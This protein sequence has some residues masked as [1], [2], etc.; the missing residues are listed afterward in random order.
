MK[1][2]EYWQFSNILV[3]ADI[4]QILISQITITPQVFRDSSSPPA[5]KP[6]VQPPSPPPPAQTP[7]LYDSYTSI[8]TKHP[9]IAIR[10]TNCQPPPA[11]ERDCSSLVI[12]VR[13][14]PPLGGSSTSPIAAIA[15]STP[16]PTSSECP[17]V[18]GS[19]SWA[20]TAQAYHCSYS[21]SPLRRPSSKWF[22][23]RWRGQ[24]LCKLIHLLGE[25]CLPQLQLLP[26]HSKELRVANHLIRNDDLV[27]L[28][29]LPLEEVLLH[30]LP[31]QALHV[32]PQE[33]RKLLLPGQRVRVVGAGLFGDRMLSGLG[34]MAAI[35]FFWLL[36]HNFIIYCKDTQVYKCYGWNLQKR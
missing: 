1:P 13:T 31:P 23:P 9:P 15:S 28:L 17:S 6:P 2:N 16:P 27:M 22:A 8:P 34:E 25:N 11:S 35:W 36:H 21:T 5:Q 29:L 18:A 33:G 20:P 3:Q 14:L 24:Y 7:L 4:N 19:D 10:F 30:V 32:S 12:Q 26:Q